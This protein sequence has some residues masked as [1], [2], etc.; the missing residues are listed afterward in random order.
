MSDGQTEA[1][2]AYALSKQVGGNHY[3]QYAIQPAE[4]CH[5]N[6]LGYCESIAIRY[7]TRHR[8]KNKAEDVR[9]AIHSLELLLQL[10][11]GEKP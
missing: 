3:R 9:K 10:E 2:E 8:H 5:R 1:C 7:I 6:G 11:Y 4:Y